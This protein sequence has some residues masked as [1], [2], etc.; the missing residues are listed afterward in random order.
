MV[1][2]A[3]TINMRRLY[4]ETSFGKISYL[5]REGIYPLV[6]LHGLGGSGNNFIKLDSLLNPYFELFMVDLLGHGR[7]EKKLLD[8][9][10]K[11]QCMML[12]EFLDVTEVSGRNFGMVGN[13]YGG[14]VSLRFSI[15]FGK[16]EFLILIDSAG[17]NPT[18]GESGKENLE[19]FIDRIVSIGH[20][21]DRNIMTKITQQN[22]TGQEKVTI[23]ELRTIEANTAIIWGEHDAIIGKRYGL[24][25][26]ENIPGSRFFTIREGGHTPHSS[27]PDKVASII[28]EFIF[29]RRGTGQIP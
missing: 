19:N 28:D 23:E 12:R 1:E 27:N 5:Y 18:I 8:Y 11:T 3:Q 25:I 2:Y 20:D 26:N 24:M 10:V 7:T 29:S 22:A 16:P 14:W 17:I 4:A 13:S 15:S 21:N 9:T 6:F